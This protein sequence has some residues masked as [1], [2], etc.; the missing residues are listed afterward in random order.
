MIDLLK[1]QIKIKDSQLKDQ[2]EQLRETHELTM[3]LTGTVLQQGQ[4][5]ENMLRLGEG[6]AVAQG[7]VT[8]D[9]NDVNEPPDS[10]KPQ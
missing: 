2:G 10:Q 3:K 6:K 4:K 5:I 7:G 8:E 9:R 1:E